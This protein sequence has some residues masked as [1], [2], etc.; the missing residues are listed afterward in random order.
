MILDKYVLRRFFPVF[1]VAM[2]MFVLLLLLIDLFANLWRYLAYEASIKDIALVAYYY[3]PKCI[4]YALP[5][6]LLFAIAF[7]FGELYAKNELTIIFTS[8][9]PIWR[10]AA[11]M[12][13]LGLLLSVASFFFED[14]L[15]ISSLKKKNQ[16]ASLMLRQDQGGNNSD[17]VVKTDGGRLVYAVDYY[18]EEE[19]TLNGLT[20]VERDTNGRFISLIRSRQANYVEGEWIL[21]SPALYQWDNGYLIHSNAPLQKMYTESPE[22]FR[23]NAVAVEELSASQASLFIDDLK[24][25]GLPYFGALA[26][27]HRRFAFSA[28]SFIVIILSVAIG[29]RFRKNILLMSLLS[30]LI[31]AVIYYVAQMISMMMAKLGYIAPLSGAWLPVGIFIILGLILMRYART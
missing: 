24:N 25:A 20:I 28:T 19:K 5:V 8:G 26:D 3:I 2:S 27:Y 10:F 21:Q 11:P 16:L 7:V 18:N 31:S 13:V 23:R 17:V 29:G 15:V 1:I 22:T 9:I 6:S 14:R 4:S 30:S 12:L